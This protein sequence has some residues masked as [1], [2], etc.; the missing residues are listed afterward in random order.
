MPGFGNN[1]LGMTVPKLMKSNYDNWSIQI[2][3][4]LGAQDVW[5]IVEIRYV[6]SEVGI[7]LTAP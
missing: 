3:V 5:D 2:L 1:S 6:E 7:A 4:L